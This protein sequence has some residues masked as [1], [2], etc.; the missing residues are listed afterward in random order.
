VK[1][2]TQNWNMNDNRSAQLLREVR[3]HQTLP[4][5]WNT[6]MCYDIIPTSVTQKFNIGDRRDT[7]L[8]PRRK[9]SFES[10]WTSLEL[11]C[12]AY[13]SSDW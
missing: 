10:E 5:C 8:L 13:I 12:D 4:T 2:S 1:F 7:C 11:C 9:D 3:K 6:S